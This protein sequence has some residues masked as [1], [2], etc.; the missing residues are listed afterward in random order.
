[1]QVGKQEVQADEE[2][3][4]RYYGPFDDVAGLWDVSSRW[5][6]VRYGK[7]DL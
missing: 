2:D 1:M 6:V 4:T 7:D 3:E 5:V